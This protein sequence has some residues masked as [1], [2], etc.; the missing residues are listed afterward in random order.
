MLTGYRQSGS[1]QP[2]PL[3]HKILAG[4][5]PHIPNDRAT[6]FQSIPPL[7]IGAAFAARDN[8]ASNGYGLS[9]V[10]FT[11]QEALHAGKE[12]VHA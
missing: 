10:F 6:P 7:F 5:G 11:N 12:S 3:Y 8:P 4:G 1:R 2:Q 9:F